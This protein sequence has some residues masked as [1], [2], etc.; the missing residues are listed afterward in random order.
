VQLSVGASEITI[1]AGDVGVLTFTVEN[2][3]DIDT[4]VGDIVARFGRVSIGE[5]SAT[6]YVRLVDDEGLWFEGGLSRTTNGTNPEGGALL[7]SPFSLGAVVKTCA[8]DSDTDDFDDGGTVHDVR[9]ALDDGA[10]EVPTGAFIAGQI[11]RVDVRVFAGRA[12]TTT[13]TI[14]APIADGFDVGTYST[15]EVV[16]HAYRRGAPLE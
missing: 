3:G 7:T 10:I 15:T 1:D 9:V 2:A 13:F 14:E 11:D 12:F 16:A 5:G 6:N 4:P 8:A